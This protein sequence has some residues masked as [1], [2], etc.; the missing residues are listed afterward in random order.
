LVIYSTLVP[1]SPDQQRPPLGVTAF[2]VR[3]HVERIEAD[4]YVVLPGL[5]GS[6]ELDPMRGQLEPY[7]ADAPFGRN[8]FEGFHTQRIYALLAKVPAVSALVAHPVILAI[9]DELLYPSYLLSAN[10]AIN[11]HPG[12]TAQMLHPDDGYC[13]WPR[14]RAA[15][16][17]S[18]VWAIDDFTEEN[19]AT[20]IVPGSHKWASA[21]GDNGDPQV[22]RIEMAAGSVVVFLGTTLHR[23]GA[24][25]G[26]STRLGI[27]PQYCEPWMRQIENMTL[28]IPPDLARALPPRVQDLIGYSL[29]PPFIGYVDGLHPQR[30]LDV[31]TTGR[32]PDDSSIEPSS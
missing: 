14:P 19:G 4:G 8:D 18:A 11:V 9:L 31:S 32:S 15:V 16:G 7:L 5:V 20:E 29:Y 24:H 25:R 1:K 26:Q 13:P 30:L 21:V 10:I 3:H 22:Y 6:H 27:T 12:E 17:V 23:G 2:D 28:A